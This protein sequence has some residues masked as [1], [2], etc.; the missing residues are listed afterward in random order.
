V[1]VS[2]ESSRLDWK[3]DLLVLAAWF[4][5]L[6]AVTTLGLPYWLSLPGT[7]FVLFYAAWAWD[8]LTAAGMLLVVAWIFA[9]ISLTLSGFYWLCLYVSYLVLRLA[10]V[11][12]MLKN[13]WQF[14]A[15]IFFMALFLEFLQ[16][17][18]LSQVY[19]E[20][21]PGVSLYLSVLGSVFIQSLGALVFYE[22]LKW[23]AGV[24]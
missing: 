19:E 4:I 7:I 8:F 2:P 5:W 20:L 1:L 14:A 13:A 11:R 24:R 12:V 21:E 16:M 17:G 22:P 3:R 23:V 9:S 18:I 6:M 10:Q 15:A